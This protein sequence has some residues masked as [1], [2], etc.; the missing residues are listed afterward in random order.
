MHYLLP[1]NKSQSKSGF[2]LVEVLGVAPIVILVIGGFVALMVSMVGSVLATRDQN[3]MMYDS[4]NAMTMIEQDVKLSGMFL[5]GNEIPA[6]SPQGYNDGAGA[7]N[8]FSNVATASG[9]IGPMLI[10]RTF[11]TDINPLNSD[12]QTVYTNQPSFSCNAN[13]KTNNQRFT[14][15][16]IYFTKENSDGSDT[17][18][19]RTLMQQGYGTPDLCMTGEPWQ[20]PSCAPGVAKGSYCEVDDIRVADNVTSFYIE[21]FNGAEDTTPSLSAANSNYTVNTRNDLLES[22]DTIRVNLTIGDYI[23]GRYVSTTVATRATRLNVASEPPTIV[24]LAVKTQPISQ[25]ALVSESVS[26]TAQPNMSDANVQWQRR[27]SS[28]GSWSNISGATSTTYTI[29]NLQ[30]GW[31]NYEYRAVMS[32]GVDTATSNVATLS[33]N[34][35]G[36]FDLQNSW[37][38]YGGSYATSGFTRT[39]TG[40]ILLKGLI[41]RSGTPTNDEIIGVLPPGYRPA[42]RLL[43]QTISNPNVTARLDITED[44]AIRY[45]EGSVGWLSLEGIAFVPA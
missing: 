42:D 44:G 10:L 14:S 2:T 35:W 17:L 29:N 7:I 41:K 25:S 31:N 39:N 24:S 3:K 23:A 13:I 37:T 43:L 19:R 45:K 40:V 4:Q 27:T 38:D 30:L 12:R 6:P 22:I 33:V 28:G 11:T 5:A 32:D 15:N 36:E 16:T 21:Y 34:L 1:I 18:W 20:Q 26:F 9:T 8:S